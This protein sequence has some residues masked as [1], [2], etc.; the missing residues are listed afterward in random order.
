MEAFCLVWLLKATKN[1]RAEGLR[2]KI[3]LNYAQLCKTMGENIQ[4]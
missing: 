2:D 1:K 3:V 4:F